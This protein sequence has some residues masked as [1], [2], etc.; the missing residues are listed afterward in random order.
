MITTRKIELSSNR[1]FIEHAD[2]LDKAIELLQKMEIGKYKI[3]EEDKI[4]FLILENMYRLQCS[5]NKGIRF[6]GSFKTLKVEIYDFKKEYDYLNK[7]HEEM[8]L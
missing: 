4:Y 6:L 3:N 7:I 8:N 5:L 1:D 2:K